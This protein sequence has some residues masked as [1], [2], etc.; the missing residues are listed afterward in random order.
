LDRKYQLYGMEDPHF[1][2]TFYR[3]GTPLVV[4]F[5]RLTTVQAAST[6]VGDI[7][8]VTNGACAGF[9]SLVS[10]TKNNG[11]P[12]SFDVTATSIGF[13]GPLTVGT[14]NAVGTPGCNTCCPVC[15]SLETCVAGFCGSTA[16]E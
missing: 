9:N 1:N 13:C 7:V 12:G 4:S 14:I 2:Y 11:N 15:G 8:D 6:I 5:P 3:N 10:V 16:S